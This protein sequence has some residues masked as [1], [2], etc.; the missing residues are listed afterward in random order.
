VEDI[1]WVTSQDWQSVTHFDDQLIARYPN[2]DIHVS[3]RL[4]VNIP[5]TPGDL[6]LAFFPME[7]FEPAFV[8]W[9]D[10]AQAH[11]RAG[12]QNMDKSMFLRFVVLLL[13]MGLTGLRRREHYF[14]K[15]SI[16]PPMSQRTF[17]NILYTIRDAG[18]PSYN[19]GEQ[20]PDGRQVTADDPLS[21]VRRF[22]DELRQHWQ[23]LF[24]PGSVLVADETMIGW[25]G[26]TDIHLTVLPNKP[27]P[28]GVCLKTIVDAHTRVMINFEFVERK[29]EQDLKRYV[30]EG[31]STAVTLR[32]T[33]PWHNQGPRLVLADAWFGSLPASWALMKRGL[34]SILNVKNQTKHFCKE[35][36]WADAGG[37]K[38]HKRNDRAYRQLVMNVNGKDTT[39]TGAFHMDK[40][41]MTL[42]A[43]AGSSNEAPIV[44][45]TRLYIGDD[46]ERVDWEG[47]L[48]QPIV[49]Y[50][51]RT[52]FNAVDVHNKLAVGPRSVCKVLVGGLPFKIWL[53]LLAMA[54]TNAYLLY[55]KHKKFT[56]EQYSHP[57]FKEDLMQ[58]LLQVAQTSNE[59]S[60]EATGVR[61]RRS[62]D[63]VASGAPVGSK[64]DR[65]RMPHGWQGHALT[66]NE[67]RNRKCMVCETKTKMLCGCG[68]AICGGTAGVTC[69]YWHLQDVSSGAISEQPVAW[70]RGK[71]A[72]KS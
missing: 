38:N 22:A 51:Y 2:F 46:G 47:D 14:S 12:L 3:G 7:L 63:S 72:R 71:R 18:F 45:R 60:E 70:Q 1:K 30:N 10:H 50:I 53:G 21:L 56:S 48:Q 9:R 68:R 33:E 5:K 36:L 44:T 25:T 6:F 39:F 23:E 35:Q 65:Q 54:E 62:D 64:R 41:Q 19:T 58:D 57:D 28:K 61:T 4:R 43:T 13:R 31:K 49:H 66:R 52:H 67:N 69:H 26:A 59:D 16:P 8:R 34:F 24:T 27:V 32:L 42:L 55:V 17:E 11:G 37:K 15:S 40:K 29:D 20:L